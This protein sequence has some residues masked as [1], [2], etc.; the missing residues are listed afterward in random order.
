MDIPEMPVMRRWYKCPYCGKKLFV[1][2]NTVKC[3]GI[4]LRCRQC[5]KEIK[6]T[7]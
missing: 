3:K 4:Y 2:D 5:R 1:Y 7:I 6:I